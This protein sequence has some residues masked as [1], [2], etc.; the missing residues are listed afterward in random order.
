MA[1]SD[2]TTVESFLAEFSARSIT[3]LDKPTELHSG[4][5]SSVVIETKAGLAS[6]RLVAQAGK[7]LLENTIPD[8]EFDVIVGIGRG[9][10]MISYSLGFALLN[11]GRQNVGLA[12]IDDH[13]S[14]R[15]GREVYGLY[16][17]QVEGLRVWGVDDVTSTGESLLELNG[18]VRAAGGIIVQDTVLVDRSK[19]RARFALNNEGI[20]TKLSSLLTFDP[21]TRVWAPSRNLQAL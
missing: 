4:E 1:E 17:H 3:V 12:G 14:P 21:D 19:G 2:G 5:S 11:A 13:Y 7:L 10:T 18:I 8:E 20:K 9:G 16:G 6:A 15:D